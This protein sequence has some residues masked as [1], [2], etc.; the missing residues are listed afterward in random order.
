MV[1]IKWTLLAMAH[2]CKEE[3]TYFLRLPVNSQPFGL[4]FDGNN[5][6]IGSSGN[7]SVITKFNLV[8]SQAVMIVRD[9]T[10]DCQIVHGLDS[11][12]DGIAFTN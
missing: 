1:F 7:D 10:P 11:T 3:L 9:G 4:A 2:V 5:L 8:T 6:F 12:S